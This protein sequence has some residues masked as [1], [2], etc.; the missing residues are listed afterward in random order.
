MQRRGSSYLP[1]CLFITFPRSVLTDLPSLQSVFSRRT[2]GSS[3]EIL[4]VKFSH[5]LPTAVTM[6]FLSIQTPTYFLLSLFHSGKGHAFNVIY[7]F[8]IRHKFHNHIL[9]STRPLT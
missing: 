6:Q 5:A 8:L 3:Y 4:E 7:T 1:C 2:N 9:S